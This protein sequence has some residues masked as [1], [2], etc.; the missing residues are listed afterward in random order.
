[1]IWCVAFIFCFGL[2]RAET[3]FDFRVHNNRVI[4]G[5]NA[6]PHVWKWQVSLQLDSNNDGSY[7]HICGGS[8]V[9]T[10]HVLTAAHCIL[11]SNPQQ[12]RAVVGE[13]N[14]DRF[15]GTEQFLR[16]HSIFVHP[17]WNGDLALGNDIAVLRLADSPY[18]NGYIGIANLPYSGDTLPNGFECFIT[19][20][21]LT[22]FA[23][24]IPDILQEA[25]ILVVEH[26]VC[27]QPDWW[28]SLVLETMVCA[29]G[30]GLISGCQ[31]DSGGPLNCYTDGAWRVHGVVSYGP[32]GMCN[33][34]RK[35]TVFT[36]VSSF[37]DWINLVMY[38]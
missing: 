11:S 20:W 10:F 17:H 29:G 4:G 5:S 13:Y 25:P 31:G 32:A 33:Q 21:G 8:L 16:V 22:D 30:D 18:D 26:S 23:G 7:F 27:S 1:M 12:Y 19:G 38:T 15:E 37:I 9:D 6:K 14:L 36:R 28:G 34:L 3:P 35:P 24:S 2:V